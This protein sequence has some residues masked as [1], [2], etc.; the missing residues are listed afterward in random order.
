MIFRVFNDSA[1]ASVGEHRTAYS[2]PCLVVDTDASY[3]TMHQ[4]ISMWL[5]SYDSAFVNND[6]PKVKNLMI[7]LLA[8]LELASRYTSLAAAPDQWSI[9]TVSLTTRYLESTEAVDA[10]IRRE[11]HGRLFMVIYWTGGYSFP[12]GSDG[13]LEFGR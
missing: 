1:T 7:N 8:E 10:E 6:Y 2:T 11:L 12:Q 3:L 5:L 9:C 13:T 4:T